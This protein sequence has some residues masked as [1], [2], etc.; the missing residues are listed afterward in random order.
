MSIRGV[1][2]SGA[3]GAHSGSGGAATIGTATLSSGA[4]TVSTTSVTS[5]AKIFV[6][7]AAFL[8]APGSVSVANRVNGSSFDI[9]STSASDNSSVNWIIEEPA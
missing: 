5:T 8:G 1:L 2:H 7:Y 9:I 3:G 4:V 6:T